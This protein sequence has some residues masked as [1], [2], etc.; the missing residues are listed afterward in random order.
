MDLV[1]EGFDYGE[2][3][4]KELSRLDPETQK[5]AKAALQLLQENSKAAT[6]RCRPRPGFGRPMIW[7]I[8]VY[9]NKS[10]QITFEMVGREA[11]LKRIAKHSVI[12]RDPRG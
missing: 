2:K 5:A 9:S 12:D 1:V 6:L 11:H 8:D 10:Y 7:K 3:F 4:V